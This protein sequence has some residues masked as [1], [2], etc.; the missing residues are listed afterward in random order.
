MSR[1]DTEKYILAIETSCDETSAAVSK[2]DWIL[3]N[4]VSSQVNLHQ[5]W[6]GV[7]PD[8]ARRAHKKRIDSVIK[9][10]LKRAQRDIE[11]I[12]YIAAT[13]G[14]GLA[15]ALEVG[16]SKAQMLARSHNNPF[17]AVNH[18]EGHLLSSLAKNSKGNNPRGPKNDIFPLIGLLVS[19]GH[20]Q[21]VLVKEIGDYELLGETLDDAAGEAF[22]KVAKML[23]LGYPGGPVISEFAKKGTTGRFDLPVP[24]KNSK[25]LN[26]SYSGLKTACLYKIRDFKEAHPNIP[27]KDWVYDFCSDFQDSVIKSITIK[28]EQ[29][30][31]K[32]DIKSVLM[33]GGV[34]SNVALRRGIR[35]SMRNF[36]IKVYQP[37][38]EKLFTDNAGMIA[39]AAYYTL[40]NEKTNFIIN[41]DKYTVD[42]KPTASI[43]TTPPQKITKE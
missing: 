21:L 33:G 41:T 34:I 4:V 30:V 9:E 23:D 43:N 25:D 20:T 37:H 42:R 12:D 39:I 14:P 10:A 31:K 35:K 28:L 2:D 7:V 22:D 36:D 17:I 13:F 11:D 15:I 16:L 5:K 29:A 27:P 3:S 8:I 32:H 24:M 40:Q 19:G 38:K 6:G 18:M 1:K 26:F